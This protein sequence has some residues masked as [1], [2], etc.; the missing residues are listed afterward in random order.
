VHMPGGHPFT[1][2]EI[3][4]PDRIISLFLPD[5]LTIWL[6]SPGYLSHLFHF[7]VFI[8]H[9]SFHNG[10][11]LPTFRIVSRSV[12]SCCSW[13]RFSWIFL[14]HGKRNRLLPEYATECSRPDVEVTTSFCSVSES[15][16][17]QSELSC[18]IQN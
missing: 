1:S 5:V 4:R 6:L 17:W 11:I 16:Q 12:R 7:L 10:P 14:S 3:G 15:L 8:N 9:K 18:G 2:R 13:W